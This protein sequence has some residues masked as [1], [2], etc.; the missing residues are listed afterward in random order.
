M[1]YK[2]TRD[3]SKYDIRGLSIL[4]DDGMPLVT[5]EA[6]RINSHEP[7]CIKV[8]I[9]TQDNTGKNRDISDETLSKLKPYANN[10]V[11][12]LKKSVGELPLEYYRRTTGSTDL[13]DTNWL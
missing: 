9:H 7:S 13:P 11:N 2:E 3:M 10:M 1:E 12:E 5:V 6:K 4:G 8:L